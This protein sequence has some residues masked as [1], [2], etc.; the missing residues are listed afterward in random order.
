M[1]SKAKREN[2][3]DKPYTL[4]N[5]YMNELDKL[6]ALFSEKEEI[7]GTELVQKMGLMYDDEKFL[8]K[9]Y[10]EMN[11]LE[12]NPGFDVMSVILIN[13][14]YGLKPEWKRQARLNRLLGE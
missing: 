11:V 1:P 10:R 14:R 13:N 2:D 6:L 12:P 8:D 5:Q 7:K 3:L 4:I 9:Y